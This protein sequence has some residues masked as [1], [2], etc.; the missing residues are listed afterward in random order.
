MKVMLSPL[1]SSA[2]FVVVKSPPMRE[3]VLTH[4]RPSSLFLSLCQYQIVLSF[5]MLQV[6]VSS[7]IIPLFTQIL[8]KNF[9]NL[10][11]SLSINFFI[12]PCLPNHDYCISFICL[13]PTVSEVMLCDFLQRYHLCIC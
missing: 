12:V 2:I 11:I 3:W 7:R 13:V 8:M 9:L 1:L 5:L 10:Y 6:L 4:F